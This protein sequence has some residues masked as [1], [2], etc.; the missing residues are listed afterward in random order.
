MRM[1]ALLKSLAVIVC[2]LTASLQPFAQKKVTTKKYPSLFWEITGNGL[3]KPSYLF[4]TM[5]V[6]SK[7]VFHLSDSF[8]HALRSTDAVALEL[9]PQVWQDQMFRMQKAQMDIARF[10]NPTVADYINEKSFQLLN[11]ED[12]IQKALSE[13]PTIVNSLLYRSFQ[14]RAD[15][16]EN[17]YLDLYI[18]QTGR[19]LGK[20]PAGVED[21]VET[22]RLMR[23]AYQDMVKEKSKKKINTDG[24]SMYEIEKKMQEAY[25]KGDLDLMDSLETLTITSPA[26]TEKFLYLRNDIQANS[27]DTILKKR[28]LF[29]GVGAAHLPGKRGVIDLLKKKGYQLRPIFMSDRDAAQKE[30]IDKLKVPVQFRNVLT[31]D[32]SIELQ[33]PGKFY[34]RDEV[35]SNESWQY[36]DMD[37]GSY[38]MLTRV[39]NHAAM[40]GQNENAILKKVDSMLYENIPGK[41]ISKITITKNGFPGYDITN[42]TRL[43]NIQRYN[44]IVTPFE[45]LVFKMSGIDEYVKG[46]EAET[47]FNSI[48]LKNN[49]AGTWR[50]YEPFYGG[51]KVNLP[52]EPN[53]AINKKTADK[54]DRWEYEAVDEKTGNAY[55]VWKKTVNNFSFIEEDTFDLNLIQESFLGSDIVQKQLV[56]TVGFQNKQPYREA[57]YA[58]KDG[59]YIVTRSF[60]KGPHYYLLAGRSKDKSEKFP[61]F[62]NSFNITGFKY[63]APETYVDSIL[64]LQVSTSVKPQLDTAL[65]AMLDKASSTE[66]LTGREVYTNYPQRKNGL[67][68][69]ELTGEA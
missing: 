9:N 68:K 21:Y 42:R 13:E 66:A 40:L 16:E 23:E 55:M 45:V 36:A 26:F 51:F 5:H 19:K 35:R 24:V 57:K 38:Y 37:N 59:G 29:V 41:I 61:D 22:E 3:K 48:S 43:G 39:R 52:H 10:S 32:G 17:T 63:K 31:D 33:L 15:F 49:Y 65:R 46:K 54:L 27:I 67:F 25:R 7:M 4:G 28:S 6:S 30:Q 44:I 12:D 56:S 18:Y 47:F 8:Y 11:Y 60:I 53:T 62:F 69:S 34:K 1:K 14:A 50:S 58:L 2:F 64:G 20:M